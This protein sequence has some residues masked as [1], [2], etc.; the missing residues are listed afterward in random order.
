MGTLPSH[1]RTVV[2]GKACI[3]KG[4]APSTFLAIHATSDPDVWE[5]TKW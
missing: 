2:L 1:A 4:R 5:Q 3:R